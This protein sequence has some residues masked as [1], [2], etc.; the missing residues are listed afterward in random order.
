MSTETP[1]E[2]LQALEQLGHR[3]FRP[4]QECTVMRILSGERR[5]RGLGG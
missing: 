5:C 3:A 1:A 2:V 4:G